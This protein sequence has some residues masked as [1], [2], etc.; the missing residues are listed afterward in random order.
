M[1]VNQK[2]YENDCLWMVKGVASI[3]VI[4]FHCP[5]EGILGEGIIYALRF[6]I[7]IFFMSTGYFLYKKADYFGKIKIYLKYLFFAE[8][9][10]GISVFI[11]ILM[12]SSFDEFCSLLNLKFS[13][14]TLLFGSVF[15][16]TLWY[17][18]AM[19]WTFIFLYFL[20]R[21]RRGFAIGY[22]FVPLLLFLHIAGRVYVTNHYDINEWVFLF[23][24]S[25]LFAL[26]FVL[27]GRFIAEKQKVLIINYWSISI[28]LCAGILLMF[29]E[30]FKWHRFMDLQVSTIF[31]S[32]ALFLF[33]LYKTD[34]KFFGLFRY[35]G[36]NLLLYVY[37]FH[38]PVYTIVSMIFRKF[39]IENQNLTTLTVVICTVGISYFGCKVKKMLTSSTMKIN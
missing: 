36:K 23:R 8:S 28:L 2:K 17:L 14:K 25:V 34:F 19:I 3:I 21:I 15:N 26:P 12:E 27:I 6:P 37:I 30:Y 35:I 5:I 33:A 13:L 18:Y 1:N 10:A 4:L 39:K 24:S 31:I 22:T 20:S 16:D 9:V 11:K 7:P 29:F 38:I 32:I